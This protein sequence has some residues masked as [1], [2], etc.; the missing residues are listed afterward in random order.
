MSGLL[1][2][3]AYAQGYGM[4]NVESIGGEHFR[5]IPDRNPNNRLIRH[6][7]AIQFRKTRRTP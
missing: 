6:R 2:A 3:G 1:V 5:L 7:K 4:C